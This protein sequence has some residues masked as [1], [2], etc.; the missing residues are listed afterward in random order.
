MRSLSEG[1]Y[2]GC[3]NYDGRAVKDAEH[4]VSVVRIL[5]GVQRYH[6]IHGIEKCDSYSLVGGDIRRCPLLKQLAFCFLGLLDIL[7]P[8]TMKGDGAVDRRHDIS[9][10]IK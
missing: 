1:M 5:R 10:S 4:I 2:A 6:W 7:Q 9:V 3:E 8:C